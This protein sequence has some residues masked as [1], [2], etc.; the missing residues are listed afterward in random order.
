MS[1]SLAR[2]AALP[3]DTQVCCAHEYTLS[4]L[5]FAAAVEPDNADLLAYTALVP[6]A[7][8]GRAADPAHA[9]DR[10]PDQP[11]PALR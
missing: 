5:R 2:L 1:Q 3:D 6:G 7:A 11:L 9:E 4:N 8:S 10:T